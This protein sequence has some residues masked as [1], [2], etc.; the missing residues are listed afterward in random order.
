MKRY[1]LLFASTLAIA[2]C[3]PATPDTVDVD[4]AA[5]ETIAASTALPELAFEKFTLDNG[6]DVILHVDESDPLV[7]INLA[8]HVGSAREVPGKTGFAHLFEH[9]LFLDS[10]NLGYGGLDAMNTRIGGEGTNGFT[11]TDMTQYF[12]AVPADALEKVVWAEADKIGW[13][14]N[15]VNQNVIDREKQVVKNEKRQRVDNQPYGHNFYVIGKALYPEG[16]PYN[17]TVIGSLE[18]L[19]SATLQDTKDFFERWYGPNNVTVT[20][21]GDFDINA[22]RRHVTKY[23]GEIPR[24]ADI[25]EAEPQPSALSETVSFVHEDNFATLPQLT[26]VWPAVP[27]YHPDSYALNVL[28]TYLT[29]GKRAPMNAVLIDEEQL[30][31]SVSAFNYTKEL[32]GEV[33]LFV[34]AKEGDDIDAL[35]P[36]IETAFARFEAEGIPEDALERIKTEAEVGVYDDIQSA[37]GKAIAM[38]EYNLF[39]DDPGYLDDDI[40]ALRAVTADD[41]M[42]VYERYIKDRPYVATSFVPKGQPALALE[43]AQVA[44]VVEEVV[45]QG[46]DADVPYDPDAR[47]F[48]PT[49]SAFDRTVEP[50]FG[51]AYEL[52]V[53]AIW[54]A[55][56]ENGL[57]IVGMHS[58]EV[59]LIEFSIDFDAGKNRASADKPGVAAMA[60][61]LLLKGA[62]DLDTAAFEDALGNLGSE[63]QV[64]TGARFTTIRGKTLARNLAETVELLDAMVNAPAFDAT[65]FDTLKRAYVQGAVSQQ[66]DPNFLARQAEARLMYPEDSALSVAGAGTQAQI[67]AVT[68]DDLRDFHARHFDVSTATLNIVGDYDQDEVVSLFGAIGDPV[69][70]DLEPKP[71]PA[72][73]DVDGTTIYFRDVPEA[74]QSVIR[75]SRPSVTSADADY[76]RLDALNFPLGGIYTSKL[77]TELRVNKGYTY[78]IGSGVVADDAAGSFVVRTSVRTN[79]TRESL[80]LI[81]DIIAAHGRDMSEDELEELKDALMRGQALEM[82]TLSDKLRLVQTISR[83]G[84]PADFKAADMARI[85]SMTAED[86]RA[87]S[88]A[89]FRPDAMRIVIV[90]DAA[91]QRAR[92]DDL[93]Y[94]VVELD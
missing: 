51:A 25:P 72:M 19:Q 41:V 54:Q 89:H 78:G 80:E 66:A 14:I 92:L 58:D 56:G 81:R 85:Q 10:E 48:E 90:G 2:A 77:M 22:A 55:E 71:R 37:L 32:A 27:E 24:G 75:I 39:R 86:A 60:G 4:G 17:H 36:A 12:Q 38:A 87:L 1:A 30:T 7:A 74:K 88:E 6:L 45:V 52:P 3:G 21:T 34:T 91:S 26:L 11:T 43:G 76:P 57:R 46:A 65:E 18:D 29:D 8:V 9:L 16:H 61:D 13:F 59:P 33:Y 94:E 79:A 23:F 20:I 28:M 49:P 47:I 83:D 63:L 93:G 15:T 82:E 69:A 50:P 67:E 5:P 84:R 53:P 42:E 68:L 70:G 31:S 40:A 35:M 64:V 73:A 44:E 62:G